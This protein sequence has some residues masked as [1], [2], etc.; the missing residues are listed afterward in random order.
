MAQ[1]SEPKPHSAT[2]IL[3]SPVVVAIVLICVL[4]GAVF[5]HWLAD[6]NAPGKFYAPV[7]FV[8]IY[9]V[10]DVWRK[11]KSQATLVKPTWIGIVPAALGLL[12]MLAGIRLDIVAI[13]SISFVFVLVG[14]CIV[15]MG[16]QRT[17][18]LAAPL[19]LI[20]AA[21]PFIPDQ[22]FNPIAP[23]IQQ[24]S[25]QFAASILSIL[26]L[27]TVE[28]GMV[29]HLDSFVSAVEPLPAGAH[30]ILSLLVASAAYVL[31]TNGNKFKRL[32][33]AAIAIPLSVAINILR[34]VFEGAIGELT[35]REIAVFYHG[36][37][38]FAAL[39]L[40]AVLLPWISLKLGCRLRSTSDLSAEESVLKSL[41]AD[42]KAA[43][44][45]TLSSR[46]IS[47]MT[48]KALPLVVA[49]DCL[50]LVGIGARA[51]ILRPVHPVTPIATFQVPMD[52]TWDGVRYTS[53]TRA[54]DP[55][56]DR[57]TQAE[58]D[59]LIPT[60][61]INRIYKGSD[62]SLNQVFITCGSGRT[63]FHDP[64]ACMRGANTP[65]TDVARP[66]ITTPRGPLQVQES[67]FQDVGMPMPTFMMYCYVVNGT[68]MQDAKQIRG[69]IMHQM[70]VNDTGKASYFV[71]FMPVNIGETAIRKTQLTHFM[72]GLWNEIAPVMKGEAPAQADP[73]P[74]VGTGSITTQ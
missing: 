56:L 10:I 48:R 7:L 71:R 12:L 35:N 59:T 20:A 39:L 17:R 22:V 73:S 32:I 63:T 68:V 11:A 19:A 28:S 3:I 65:M 69:S 27:H 36:Y 66:V 41:T 47:T 50:F 4:Y 74:V 70:L 64:H 23:L 5:M 9:F 40:L 26:Q 2:P 54:Q 49:T 72:S 67:T 46:P 44:R 13:Q 33:V 8:P 1:D 6:W 45:D 38:G 15:T 21:I 24:R 30:I 51:F 42:L 58:A 31:L 57:I 37:S 25:S 62:G 61:V 18:Q 52:F 29:L 60:R 16:I 55:M 43:V 53:T 14:A 34:L